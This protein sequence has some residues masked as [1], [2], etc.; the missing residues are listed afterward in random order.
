MASNGCRIH[1][2]VEA[3]SW[4]A[5]VPVR[6]NLYY[7]HLIVLV[8]QLTV[9]HK[10]S[11]PNYVRYDGH[12]RADFFHIGSENAFVNQCFEIFGTDLIRFEQ[13]S[14]FKM[15]CNYRSL[16]SLFSAQSGPYA[17]MTF[18]IFASGKANFT[19]QEDVQ[20]YDVHNSPYVP[21][22]RHFSLEEQRRRLAT[23]KNTWSHPFIRFVSAFIDRFRS[24]N[25]HYELVVAPE[26]FKRFRNDSSASCLKVTFKEFARWVIF[27]HN[28]PDTMD[29]HWKPLKNL[30]QP[31]LINYDLI[32][33]FETLKLDTERVLEE[34]N[35]QA[36]IIF[37]V[38]A[39][40]GDFTN[41]HPEV[42]K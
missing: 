28:N 7:L 20:V 25:S 34:V 37:P 24:N 10:T 33:N 19:S 13:K 40:V 29:T 12:L 9:S 35:V 22:L 32:C 39:A 27:Y 15:V 2:N 5:F 21:R 6:L 8:K 18:G 42:L 26:I 36:D 23:Y 16:C 4:L 11:I 30:C 3:G 14:F 38:R 1:P 41:R 17:W 31:C